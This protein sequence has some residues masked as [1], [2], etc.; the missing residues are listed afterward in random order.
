MV[1]P[2]RGEGRDWQVCAVE[3]EFEIEDLKGG[4][5]GFSRAPSE[6]PVL[7]AYS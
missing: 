5:Q 4:V 1:T 2:K 7:L 3:G 6:A